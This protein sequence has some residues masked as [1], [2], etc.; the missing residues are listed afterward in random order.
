MLTVELKVNGVRIGEMRIRRLHKIDG[1]I[2]EYH[3][4]YG[5]DIDPQA[6][7]GIISHSQEDGAFALVRKVL[8]DGNAKTD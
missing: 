7:Q 3:Y 4:C 2:C 1:D 6:T 8:E 5:R